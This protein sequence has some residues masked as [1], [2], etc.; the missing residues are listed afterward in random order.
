MKLLLEFLTNLTVSNAAKTVLGD[1]FLSIIGSLIVEPLTGL[2]QFGALDVR[3]AACSLFN[4]LC[5]GSNNVVKFQAQPKC[6]LIVNGMAKV[7]KRRKKEGDNTF[8]N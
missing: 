1:I 2:D 8:L 7:R 6:D 5:Y 4:L 3:I